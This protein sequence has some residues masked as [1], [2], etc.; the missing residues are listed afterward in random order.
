[1]KK[2]K[3]TKQFKILKTVYSDNI[4]NA[5]KAESKA[6]VVEIYE[7]KGDSPKDLGPAIGFGA[8]SERDY[9]D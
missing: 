9:W 2:Q 5:L 4:T 3:P 8:D 1:M 6:E 7:E